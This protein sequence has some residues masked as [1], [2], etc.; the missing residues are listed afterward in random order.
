MDVGS[1]GYILFFIGN[2]LIYLYSKVWTS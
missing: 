1:G 2:L